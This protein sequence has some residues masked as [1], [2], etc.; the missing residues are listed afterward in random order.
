MLAGASQLLME[1]LTGMDPTHYAQMRKV[2]ELQ[3]GGGRPRELLKKDASATEIAEARRIWALWQALAG[4]EEA[5]RWLLVHE[6][7]GHPLRLIERVLRSP[8]LMHAST[9]PAAR[10]QPGEVPHGQ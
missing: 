7:T 2:L 5:D 6:E 3:G 8:D 9:M 1:N 4:H 10:R